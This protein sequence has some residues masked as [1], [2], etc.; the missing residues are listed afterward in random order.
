MRPILFRIPI[1][2]TDHAIT[3]YGYGAMMC[4]GFLAAIL[5]AARRSR[6]LGQPPDIIY[7]CAL[8]AFLGGVFGARLFYIVQY[9]EHFTSLWSIVMIW[10]G[11]LTYYGGLVLA[12]VAVIAYLAA[13]RLPVLYWLD[14]M[15][16]SLPLGLA[17]G[18]IGCFLNGCCYGDT[19]DLPWGLAWPVGSIPWFDYADTYL[20]SHGAMLAGAADGPYGAVM[21]SLVATWRPPPIHPAQ[22]YAIVNALLLFAVLHVMFRHKRRHGQVILVFALLYGI[23]RFLMEFLR[24]DEASTYLLGLPTLLGALGHAEAAA[25]FGGLTVSQNV[26]IGMV[27]AAAVA[28]V[29]LMRTRG[30]EWQA[31]YAPPA[32]AVRESNDPGRKKHPKPKKGKRG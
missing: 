9:R 6:R 25:R 13:S 4:L 8:F 17:F 30:R 26:A 23:S 15:A 29:F 21:G 12:T 5:V 14:V 24:A 31:D 3:L 32:P 28:L 2:G 18:R 22:V 1:P 11:G 16:P 10:E 7:N 19:C 20:A 27:A